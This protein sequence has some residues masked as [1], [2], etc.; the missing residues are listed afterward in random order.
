[1][2]KNRSVVMVSEQGLDEEEQISGNAYERDNHQDEAEEEGDAAKNAN[3]EQATEQQ[4][5]SREQAEAIADDVNPAND[6]NN[7]GEDEFEEAEQE[8]EE[9][10]PDENE[11]QRQQD[12]AEKQEH[13]VMAG[14]PDQQED[15]VDEQYQEEG[16]E[17]VQEDLT[18]ERK[19]E[20]NAEEPYGENE[21]H[22][23]H[24][25]DDP[26]QDPPLGSYAAFPSEDRSAC[27]PTHPLERS[28]KKLDLV[29]A[30]RIYLDR[31]STFRK[32]GSLFVIPDGTRRGQLASKVTI[33]RWIRTAILEA[34]RVKNRVP[35]PGIKAH[36]TRAVGA[37][38]VV[39]HRAS[40][41][42]L[43]KAATLS[44]IHMFAK[45]YK[46]H[47]YASADASLGRRI[48][49]A[50]VV[51]LQEN[52]AGKRGLRRRRFR[53]Q[54]SAPAQYALSGAILLKTLP[55]SAYCAGADSG[56]RRRKRMAA[57]MPSGAIV[58]LLLVPESAP[59]QYALS[60]AILLKT[61]Q[62]VF[63]KM[64]PESAY[65][66]GADSGTR[67]RKTMAPEL[68]VIK[69][70]KAHGTVAN[71]PRCGRKRKIDKRFQCKIVWMLDKEPRLTSKQVKAALQS[72]GTT[73]STR[74][75]RR[76][77]NEKGL[78]VSG[79]NVD[80]FWTAIL[81]YVCVEEA[82]SVKRVDSKPA[83]YTRSRMSFF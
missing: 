22:K 83:F 78:Y 21:E 64:A 62:C 70:F 34:Y 47:T 72:E 60:G 7:Q 45:F 52:G 58:L 57:E 82:V 73:V 4:A 16:E 12:Q 18:E 49:Q 23:M 39:H 71:L 25:S 10:L 15:N 36:S 13:L 65:C 46:V 42:Q 68:A 51:C 11:E 79:K 8:R 59:A 69:K 1:M 31:T 67:R 35:P 44:S 9:N 40:V 37:S 38:W 30:V 80:S 41:L 53:Q 50:A 61:L 33:A 6:P 55:E 54:E 24:I 43:C 75:I 14:N 2:R 17:E 5:A 63:N 27:P 56:T 77:L 76:H 74:T 28:L 26:Y 29:T 48:L 66:A 19:R 32:T 81:M 20:Q 3:E